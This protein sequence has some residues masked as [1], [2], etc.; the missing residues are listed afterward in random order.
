MST[1]DPSIE[2]NPIPPHGCP[3]SGSLMDSASFADTLRACIHCGMC[4][5]SCPTYLVTGSE[6]ESPRG[7]LY[8]MN[9]F[10]QGRL[11]SPKQLSDHLDLC[12]GC[13]ACT[14]ACPSGVDYESALME[15]RQALAPHQPWLKRQIKRWLL[16][17]L[18]PSPGLLN[19]MG[20]GL[21][22]SQQLGLFQLAR[23]WKLFR[24]FGSK[25]QQATAF[26]PTVTALQPITTGGVYGENKLGKVALF[27][28]CIM[29]TLYGAVHQASIAVLVKQG[30]QVVIPPQTCCGALAYHG[31]EVDI[32]QQLARKNMAL[33][34]PDAF[35]WIVVNAAGCGASLKTYDHWFKDHV[36]SHRQAKAFASKVV[37]ILE[38]LAHHPLAHPLKPV[39][40]HVTYHAACHLHHAQRVTDAPIHLL[41]QIP[42]L[43][44]TPLTDATLCCGSAGVYNLA[45][46]E[47]SMAILQD[48][49]HHIAA[50]HAPVIATANPGCMI[51]LQAG[52]D[53]RN[54]AT[55]SITVVHP[56]ELMAQAYQ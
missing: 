14:T 37:D 41:E 17:H 48:K 40:Q 35:D 49:L 28:G 25:L 32:A 1:S 18:L 30:Y 46:P 3:A 52:L 22:I 2:N 26:T 55:Q 21:K 13:L 50:T 38:L 36:V 20:R 12:L 51:Q 23:Q 34:N 27:T 56:I 5:P 39:E 9:A 54:D 4:L 11:D 15:S 43:T 29:N 31:G 6:A 33:I 8:L 19:I 53:Q 10:R 7:R 24:L 42:G 16:K 47:M 44:I 45:Q